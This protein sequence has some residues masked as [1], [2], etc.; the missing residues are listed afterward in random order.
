MVGRSP[1]ASA[2]ARQAY[3]GSNG[4]GYGSGYGEIIYNLMG[5]TPIATAG[6]GFSQ[7]ELED[8]NTHVR[9][10]QQGIQKT[11]SNGRRIDTAPQAINAIPEY[12]ID[13]SYNYTSYLIIG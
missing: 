11:N 2:S 1:K 6:G 13:T 8:N 9:V 10:R 3:V 5:Y 4:Y 7:E 12:R